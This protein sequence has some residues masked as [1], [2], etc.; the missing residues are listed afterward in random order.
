MNIDK[1]DGV[2]DAYIHILALD[3]GWLLPV[4]AMELMHSLIP[5]SYF[6]KL[7]QLK[8]NMLPHQ[9]D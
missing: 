2:L 9:L 5:L 4:G 7:L 3:L 1:E 8:E 6:G